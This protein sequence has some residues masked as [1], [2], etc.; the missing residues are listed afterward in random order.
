M[1]PKDR[2]RCPDVP[3]GVQQGVPAALQTEVCHLPVQVAVARS[4]AALRL[5][6]QRPA[7][8]Q[9]KEV[10]K[11]LTL[12]ESS[13]YM[14]SP[15]ANFSS[16]HA[17]SGATSEGLDLIQR[18]AERRDAFARAHNSLVGD[19]DC[20]LAQNSPTDLHAPLKGRKLVSKKSLDFQRTELNYSDS[21]RVTFGCVDEQSI[22][23]RSEKAGAI[24]LCIEQEGCNIVVRSLNPD[25]P[26]AADGRVVPGDLLIAGLTQRSNQPTLDL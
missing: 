19:I 7:S 15:H 16:P 26:A 4:R 20:F 23:P 8:S 14:N 2:K 10:P 6:I 11:K 17:L 9:Y 21:R 24:G 12:L 13:T 5:R 22:T 18:S 1:V 25:G 3:V